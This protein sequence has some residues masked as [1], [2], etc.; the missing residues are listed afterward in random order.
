MGLDGAVAS[1]AHGQNLSTKTIRIVD[2][3]HD[4]DL[5]APRIVGEFWISATASDTCLPIQTAE[6]FSTVHR[7]GTAHG[8]D[9][10]NRS[11][12]A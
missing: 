6:S 12:R 2:Q 11:G 5:N 1:G 4:V 7:I 9:A 8:I 3:M 10:Q